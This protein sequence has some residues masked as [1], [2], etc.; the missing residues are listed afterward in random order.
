MTFNETKCWTYFVKMMTS[1]KRLLMTKPSEFRSDDALVRSEWRQIEEVIR[2]AGLS[3]QKTNLCITS[4]RPLEHLA[5]HQFNLHTF[6]T[7]NN[8]SFQHSGVFQRSVRVRDSIV[9]LH[10]EPRRLPERLDAAGQISD[11]EEFTPGAHLNCICYLWHVCWAWDVIG[12]HKQRPR[13]N[14]KEINA[15]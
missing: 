11:Q 2:A 15:Q 7:S 13:K 12:G 8:I 6:E 5:F 3:C 10:H 1:H 4:E 14:P 9:Q